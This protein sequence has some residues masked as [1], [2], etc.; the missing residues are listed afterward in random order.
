VVAPVQAPVAA[1]TQEPVVTATQVPAQES[2][3]ADPAVQP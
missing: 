3:P 1:A 2:A